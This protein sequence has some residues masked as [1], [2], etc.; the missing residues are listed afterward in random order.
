[1][2][3]PV[4]V[5]YPTHEAKEPV[6]RT[7]FVEAWGSYQASVQQVTVNELPHALT[8]REPVT[9]H[10]FKWHLP[11]LVSS[12]LDASNTFCTSGSICR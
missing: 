8:A 3:V 7:V 4:G 1:M 9:E 6:S 10:R 11:A 12:G 2:L 5:R